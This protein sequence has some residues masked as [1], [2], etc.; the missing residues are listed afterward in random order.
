M[1]I[2]AIAGTVSLLSRFGLIRY[3]D[4]YV[5]PDRT[6]S[7]WVKQLIKAIIVVFAVRQVYFILERGL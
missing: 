1:A 6:K 3:R 7:F 4:R 2:V 5:A